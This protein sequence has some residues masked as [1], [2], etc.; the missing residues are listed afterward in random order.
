MWSIFQIS[1]FVRF[2]P[3]TRKKEWKS[4]WNLKNKQYAW[5]IFSIS[6]TKEFTHLTRQIYE[7]ST[8]ESELLKSTFSKI[9]SSKWSTDSWKQA[10]LPIKRAG[11]A[12]PDIK[13]NSYA[14]Y[15]ASFRETL[16][17]TARTFP[18]I[19][20]M[21]NNPD[22]RHEPIQ[23]LFMEAL[24]E[25]R[26]RPYP[27]LT[28]V[29]QHSTY[30]SQWRWNR[31]RLPLG[32]SNGA[33]KAATKR[34]LGLNLLIPNRCKVWTSNHRCGLPHSHMLT[35][36]RKPP[37]TQPYQTSFSPTLASELA[38]LC[39]TSLICF[40]TSKT[41]KRGKRGDGLTY[42]ASQD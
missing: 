25:S 12:I 8:K 1:V 33:F 31:R 23:Q 20:H 42:H 38:T 16:P 39:K 14:A 15:T 29:R 9:L 13:D 41:T 10:T 32:L 19:R 17:H 6:L 35:R 21:L 24:H 26:Q 40:T 18:D 5:Q 27:Q 36:K 7:P 37:E 28:Y 4:I 30:S 11:L 22:S 34:R 3:R 2:Y